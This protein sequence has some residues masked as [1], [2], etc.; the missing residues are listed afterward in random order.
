MQFTRDAPHSGAM[1]LLTL[2]AR[3][4]LQ[5]VQ[6]S[7][8]AWRYASERRHFAQLDPATLRDLAVS[9]AEFE[10]YWFEAMRMAPRT[11]CRLVHRREQS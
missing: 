10:S 8:M 1:Q 5:L 2:A 7:R 9:R 4:T 3:R 6:R 11:R